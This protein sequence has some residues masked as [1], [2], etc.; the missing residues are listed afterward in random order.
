MI[1]PIRASNLGKSYRLQHSSQR[2][3]YRTL[4]ESLANAA[5]SPIRRLRGGDQGKSEEFWA[6]KDFD[7]EVQAGEV[8]GIIGRNG[9]GK[10][11]LLKVL[12]RITR[13]TTGRVEIRGRIGSLLEVG[14]GFHPELTG[15]ENIYLNGSILG[16][17]R[18]DIDRRF[19]EIVA[20]AE[21][22]K[23]LDMPVKRYSSGM[24]VR[25]AFAVAAHLEPDILLIDEVLAV[26]DAEFQKKC[27][28]KMNEVARGGRTI[29][30]VSHNL[31]AV[32]R[33]C[34]LSIL[35]SGG[36]A[37][38]QGAT[39]DCISEYVKEF[40]DHAFAS[41]KQIDITVEIRDE[42]GHKPSIW[43]YGKRLNFIVR[44]HSKDEIRLPAV[45][46]AFY[47]EDGSRMF[48]VQSDRLGGT[49][50]DEAVR[51]VEISFAVENIGIACDRLS[52]D[53]GLRSAAERDYLAVWERIDV[54]PMSVKEAPYQ[55]APNTLLLL[56]CQLTMTGAT[57]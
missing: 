45:D 35:V 34:S 41:N 12:S 36:R 20:F 54:I 7:F 8:V 48:V 23:F 6:L 52:I 24:Y 37:K 46:L 32:E 17:S 56:P 21:V 31:A 11:T 55:C 26:G 33:L 14:T 40:K 50:G 28:G 3:R 19:D 44:V 9:A 4:R 51:D 15:R 53:V 22:E 27:L 10:S 16:M 39:K 43:S 25:L 13:P 2:V 47:S 42:E 5:K 18:R 38:M 1:A 57:R 29:L 30:F 49:V